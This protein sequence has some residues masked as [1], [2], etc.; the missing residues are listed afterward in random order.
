MEIKADYFLTY[1]IS[2]HAVVGANSRTVTLIILA[3]GATLQRFEKTK[4]CKLAS[5]ANTVF[6]YSQA[7]NLE[8]LTI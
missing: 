1:V 5:I 6:L 3:V 4:D 2:N 8:T 7:Y